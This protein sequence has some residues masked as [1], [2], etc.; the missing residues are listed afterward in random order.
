MKIAQGL[1]FQVYD[2]G[3]KVEK[4]PTTRP[5]M[6]WQIISMQPKSLLA[7]WTLRKKLSQAYLER[8]VACNYVRKNLT[9]SYLL[10]HPQFQNNRVLQNKVL[11]LG[12]HISD[13]NHPQTMIQGIIECILNSWRHGFA[14]KT[15]NFT[16]NYGLDQAGR[17]V[18]IDFGEIHLD[19]EDV[20]KDIVSKKWERSW[21]FQKDLPAEVKA[22]WLKEMESRVTV[23]ELERC[24][25]KNPRVR[26]RA[27]MENEG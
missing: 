26:M 20:K 3:D 24:W 5:E 23:E 7:F 21:S 11:P 18:V 15:Y 14:E 1:Q 17:V 10:A 6:L 22:Y 16:N 9:N 27:R 2:Q 13:S 4:V 8:E 25:R 19:Q 12:K